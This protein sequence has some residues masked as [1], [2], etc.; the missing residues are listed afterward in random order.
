MQSAEQAGKAGEATVVKP[1]NDDRSYRCITLT[2][3][4]KALLISDPHTDKAA[5]G[6]DV[7]TDEHSKTDMTA[8]KHSETLGRFCS[9]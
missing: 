7:S 5:A 6:M 3:G 8:V 4:L 1:L 2:N 9:S